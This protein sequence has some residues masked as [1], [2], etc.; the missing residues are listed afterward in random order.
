[1]TRYT[2]HLKTFQNCDAQDLLRF[3][4]SELIQV[5]LNKYKTLSILWI[6]IGFRF[7]PLYD[8]FRCFQ[9][10]FIVQSVVFKSLTLCFTTNVLFTSSKPVMGNRLKYHRSKYWN[11]MNNSSVC[12]CSIIC[13]L[14]KWEIAL[15]KTNNSTK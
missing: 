3:A 2:E 8:I 9:F 4:K 12:Y 11:L 13:K 14:V 10:F 7:F 15:L 5:T 1:M 6:G